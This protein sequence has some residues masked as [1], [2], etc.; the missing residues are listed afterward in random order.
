M[1]SN[2]LAAQAGTGR[3]RVMAA[4]AV[5]QCNCGARFVVV[6]FQGYV[7]SASS[8][9]SFIIVVM[10][11]TIISILSQPVIVSTKSCMSGANDKML[12]CY[13]KEALQVE[14]KQAK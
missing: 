12:V 2:C 6:E 10:F 4:R 14:S 5:L 13:V 7:Q 1:A 3:F 9:H 11:V 8:K